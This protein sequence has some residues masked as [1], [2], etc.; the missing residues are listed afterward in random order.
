MPGG[1][2]AVSARLSEPDPDKSLPWRASALG[3]VKLA[4]H[5]PP[6][7]SAKEHIMRRIIVVGVTVAAVAGAGASA[8]AATGTLTNT[9]AQGTAVTTAQHSSSGATAAGRARRH[10]L[11]RALRHTVHGQVV[12]KRGTTYITHDVVHGAV[13]AVSATSIAV[14]ASDGF[15]ET[16]AVTGS[17]KVRVR[18]DGHGTKGAIGDVHDGD[19]VFVFGTGA[20]HALARHVIDVHH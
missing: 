7:P 4:K 10:L 8:L 18:T 19:T 9:A 13:T 11:R 16:F 15:S 20:D 3:I 6:A 17:T 1:P 14:K 2:D 12:T 5:Y